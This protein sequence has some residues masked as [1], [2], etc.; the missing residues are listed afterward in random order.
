MS[1]SLECA[2]QRSLQAPTVRMAGL[3]PRRPLGRTG[4]SVSVLGFGASPL[5]GVFDEVDEVRVFCGF[6]A[7]A[8]F[9]RPRHGQDEGVA[10]VHEAVRQGINFFD[11]SPCVAS[12]ITRVSLSPDLRRSF[13]GDTRAER[14]LGRALKDIPRD[15]ARPA[16]TLQTRRTRLTRCTVRAVHQSWP[17]RRL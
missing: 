3:L 7:A 16:A 6:E 5:G 12:H 4:L 13:Y 14:V 9:T 1:N 17:L 10:S 11:C 8:P 15:Q 2:T